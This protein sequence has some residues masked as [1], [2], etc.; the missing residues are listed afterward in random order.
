[1][2]ELKYMFDQIQSFWDRCLPCQRI[3]WESK[4][5][6]QQESKGVKDFQMLVPMDDVGNG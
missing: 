6:A 5:N 2:K 4:N 1:M 3:I